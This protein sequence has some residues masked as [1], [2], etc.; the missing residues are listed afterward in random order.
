MKILQKSDITYEKKFM[1]PEIHLALLS[2]LSEIELP[3]KVKTLTVTQKT[4]NFIYNSS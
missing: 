1:D 4:H 2:Y 3:N